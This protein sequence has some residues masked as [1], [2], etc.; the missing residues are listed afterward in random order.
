M[1]ETQMLEVTDLAVSY[2]SAGESHQGRFKV[3]DGL[4]LD[5][6]P[7][8]F[9]SILT[10]RVRQDDAAARDYRAG[11]SGAWNDQGSG[12]DQVQAGFGRVPCVSELRAV[13]V[14]NGAREH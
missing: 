11:E 10:E 5:V 6:A 9:V 14:A 12:R 4:S 2:E 3:L 13:P 8:E 1:P 7:G